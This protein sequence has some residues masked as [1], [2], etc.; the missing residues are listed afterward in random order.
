MLSIKFK[1]FIENPLE[2]NKLRYIIQ[3]KDVKD[4][5]HKDACS[6]LEDKIH[7]SKTVH[8][9]GRHVPPFAKTSRLYVFGIFDVSAKTSKMPKTNWTFSWWRIHKFYFRFYF[10][11]IHLLIQVLPV[12]LCLYLLILYRL[13]SSWSKC[14]EIILYWEAPKSM[15]SHLD[16]RHKSLRNT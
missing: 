11:L 14:Y 6:S 1:S 4:M 5:L 9:F 2:K 8:V 3:S 13:T 16:L 12:P 7:L 15:Q 10:L